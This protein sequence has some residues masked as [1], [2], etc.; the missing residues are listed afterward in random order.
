MNSGSNN[1][2]VV[3]IREIFL[4]ILHRVQQG[5]LTDKSLGL[6]SKASLGPGRP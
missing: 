1:W 4:D 2:Y 3:K 6:F 5:I